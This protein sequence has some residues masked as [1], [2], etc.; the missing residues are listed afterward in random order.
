MLEFK[1]FDIDD[2]THGYRA[3]KTGRISANAYSRSAEPML[4]S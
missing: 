4:K 2:K 3:E 1:P